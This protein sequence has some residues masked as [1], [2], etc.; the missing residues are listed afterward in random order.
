M[1]V[2]VHH[3]V[4]RLEIAMDD[5][6]FVRRREAGCDLPRDRQRASTGSRPSRFR[7]VARS[8]P[9]MYGIVMYLMPSISPR[10][11]MRT[12]FLCVTWRASSSSRLKRRSSSGRH[13]RIG[14]G[15]GPDHLDRDRDLE[16]LVPGL[17]DRAHAA[18]AEQPDDVVA[19]AEVLADVQRSGVKVTACAGSAGHGRG[20]PEPGLILGAEH[21]L[22]LTRP[23]LGRRRRQH[24]GADRRVDRDD[25]TADGTASG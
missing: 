9:W 18:G 23:R 13:H 11:W 20:R 1:V 6:G 19:R 24:R 15:F 8:E 25:A 10:S 17:V 7:I 5:A 22:E 21:G 4:G 3:D 2:V 14:D 16:L 12:T